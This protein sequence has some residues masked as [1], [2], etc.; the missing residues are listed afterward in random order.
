MSADVVEVN[1]VVAGVDLA[2]ERTLAAVAADLDDFLWSGEGGTAVATVFAESDAVAEADRAAARIETALPGAQVVRVQPDLVTM[3]GIA[4]RVGVSRQAVR[5][6]VTGEATPAFPA[7]FAVLEPQAKPVK[8][9][10]WADVT[11]WLWEVKGLEFERLPSAAQVAAIDA[12]LAHRGSEAGS[13][14]RPREAPAKLHTRARK[15]P[16]V[17]LGALERADGVSA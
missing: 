4:D 17:S 3:S 12:R 8:V 13:W 11:P 9:W 2:D 14:Y 6:W 7:P 16:Q 5:L 15:A 1:L 10:R